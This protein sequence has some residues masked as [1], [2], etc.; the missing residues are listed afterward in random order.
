[1]HDVV[2]VRRGERAD[3][4]H[5]DIEREALGERAARSSTASAGGQD[6]AQ[7]TAIE[8]LEDHVRVP[9]NLVHIVNDNDIVV[10]AARRRLGLGEQARRHASAVL[11]E[12]DG[13]K[14]AK[15][16]VAREQH[17]PHTAFAELAD[18]LVVL[19]EAVEQT[20]AATGRSLSLGRRRQRRGVGLPRGLRLVR[21]GVVRGDGR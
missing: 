7:R 18:D 19:D 11:K 14:A 20:R 10:P 21:A 6:L 3:D 8:V 2:R 9:V 4:R 17:D 5:H 13:D 1:V 16:G 12:L 15:L